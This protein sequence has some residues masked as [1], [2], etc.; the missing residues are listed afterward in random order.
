MNAGKEVP[1][2]SAELIL[3]GQDWALT[4]QLSEKH[5]NMQEYLQKLFAVAL[6]IFQ[7]HRKKI[8]ERIEEE[9]GVDGII[10]EFA[11]NAYAIRAVRCKSGAV[12]TAD[13]IFSIDVLSQE[14]PPIEN[15]EKA[16]QEYRVRVSFG[17]S[18]LG[19]GI[20]NVGTTYGNVRFN[21]NILQR[22]MDPNFFPDEV[23]VSES[24]ITRYGNWPP[25]TS[26]RH[27]SLQA[28]MWRPSIDGLDLGFVKADMIF[29]ATQ[30]TR[31]A[32]DQPVRNM[33][34]YINRYAIKKP[35]EAY[36]KLMRFGE[37]LK[38]SYETVV[39]ANRS[40]TEISTVFPQ[41]GSGVVIS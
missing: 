39:G 21:R 17:S 35:R 32:E 36:S 12:I 16:R 6:Q 7:V 33:F 34:S 22:F 29:T 24:V 28:Q 9:G 41:L 18:D 38:Y 40:N 23:G 11:D 25:V 30:E 19:L 31:N 14:L 20:E 4:Q 5:I 15:V 26:P 10:N 27:Y 37:L 13:E 8:A 3:E 1:Q 2:P